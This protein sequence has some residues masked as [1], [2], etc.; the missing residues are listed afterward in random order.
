MNE[1]ERDTLEEAGD[2]STPV[3]GRPTRRK[4]WRMWV[5]IGFAAVVVFLGI[6]PVE[7][8]RDRTFLCE[9]TGS[10]KGYRRWCIGVQT[11]EWYKESH[12]EQFMRQRHPTELKYHWTSYAGTGRN[13]LGQA[14]SFRH[15]HPQVGT[16][17][18]HLGFFNSYVDMLDDA[19]KLELFR[20]LASGDPSAI[21]AEEEK[22]G[23]AVLEAAAQN[24]TGSNE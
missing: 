22:I 19:G 12:L 2:A 18:M 10:H 9:N 20:V 3:D 14:G 11:G 6:L 4:R 16:V 23:A 7:V 13:L 21:K 8:Y 17:I 5:A 1:D 24:R 15:E